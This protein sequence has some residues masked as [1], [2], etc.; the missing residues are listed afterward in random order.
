MSERNVVIALHQ[1]SVVVKGIEKKLT[2]KGYHVDMVTEHFE[3]AVELTAHTDAFLLYL[4][5]DVMDD[6]VKFNEFAMLA[7]AL[8]EKKASII[9]LGEKKYRHDFEASIP[10]IR[11]YLWYDRPVDLDELDEALTKVCDSGSVSVL[12]KRILIV[13]DDPLYAGMVREWIREKYRVDVVTAGMQAITFLLKNPVDLVLLDYEMPVVDG[14]QVLQ[15]LRQDQNTMNIPVVF[16]TGVGT[17]E[18]VSRVMALKPDGYVLKSTT[19]ESLM[20]YI[21]DKIG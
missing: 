20:K 21:V 14:P 12:R 4:P 8:Q 10:N 15:M 13:D 2:E 1:F 19:K 11:D 7:S 17:K 18:E 3:K 6:K 5:S 16:L 9:F